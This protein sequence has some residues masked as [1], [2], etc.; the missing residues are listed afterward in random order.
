MVSSNTNGHKEKQKTTDHT[1]T[2]ASMTADV[3]G[4]AI[5]RIYTKIINTLTNEK[6]GIKQEAI[7]EI[8]LVLT[9][10]QQLIRKTLMH[11]CK[12]EMELMALKKGRIDNNGTNRKISRTMQQANKKTETYAGR[13]GLK[14]RTASLATHR[15]DS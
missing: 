13:R 5:D 11:K 9:E 1:Q 6:Y 3:V 15:E 14:S 10:L 7:R 2:I 8:L 4:E 12:L